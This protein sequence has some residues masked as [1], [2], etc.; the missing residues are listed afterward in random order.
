MARF[1]GVVIVITG[2]VA[3]YL[4]LN[5]PL[6]ELPA[7]SAHVPE[8]DPVDVSGPL[9]LWAAPQESIPASASVPDQ[10]TLNA[11]LYQPLLSGARLGVPVAV[12]AVLSM[13]M[14]LTVSAA[15]LPARSE[16]APEADCP[17]PSAESTLSAGG[18]PAASPES[19][20]EHAKLAVTSVLF[21]PK[22]FAAGER[23]PVIVG[24]VLS[25]WIPPAVAG[26][27][28][29]PALSVHSPDADWPAPSEARTTGA[30][31]VCTPDS[32]SL[33]VNDTVT[34]VLFHPLALGDGEADADALG[35]V[36]SMWIPP[37]VVEPELPAWSEQEP[38][39]D[40]LAPSV[41]TITSAEVVPAAGPESASLQLKLTVT[42]VLFQ[43]KPFA[44]GDG[45]P[46]TVG[47]VLS[48][49]MSVI[50]AVAELPALSEQV[51]DAD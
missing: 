30:A 28:V 10:F 37:T 24:A 39:A 34:S 42:S 6:P 35:G 8:N 44:A 27:P 15:V 16:H 45:V 48:I 20:S 5:E 1:G 2:G 7:L 9:K 43:P 23:L 51:P 38:A 33:P 21:Q 19:A 17:A 12:G 4:K 47:G 22:A 50:V 41:V 31:Q 11:L 18:L 26:A 46:V 49:L 40:W 14:P 13:L 25:I 29:F 36:L 3:S 32:P